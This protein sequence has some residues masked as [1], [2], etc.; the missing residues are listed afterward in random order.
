[1]CGWVALWHLALTYSSWGS[2]DTKILAG[3]RRGPSQAQNT[4]PR[5][6]CQSTYFYFRKFIFRDSSTEMTYISG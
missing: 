4:E 2:Q 6:Y 5:V 1:M 3:E